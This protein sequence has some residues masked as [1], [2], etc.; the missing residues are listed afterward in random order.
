MKSLK[1]NFKMEEVLVSIRPSERPYLTFLQLYSVSYSP[2][3]LKKLAS[4]NYVKSLDFNILI[5]EMFGWLFAI[6]IYKV[7]VYLDISPKN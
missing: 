7:K 4:D 5:G 1:E 2:L 3:S 6:Y